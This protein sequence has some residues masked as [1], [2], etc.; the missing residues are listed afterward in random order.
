MSIPVTADKGQRAGDK[1]FKFFIIKF[2]EQHLTAFNTARTME[3]FTFFN[4]LV[5]Y[6]KMMQKYKTGPAMRPKDLAD[7]EIIEA[8]S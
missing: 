5:L 1:L 2:A 7:M 6:S 8:L 3:C 4:S